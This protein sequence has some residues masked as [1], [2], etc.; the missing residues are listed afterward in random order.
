[1]KTI[2]ASSKEI[3]DRALELK[4]GNE[5]YLVCSNDHERDDIYEDL[6]QQRLWLIKDNLTK[7]EQVI[8][9]R[10]TLN[11]H[12]NVILTKRNIISAYINKPDGGGKIE[13]KF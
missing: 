8:I 9:D 4:I 7:Y 12:P 2:T 5:L 1:M 10:N 11:F 6:K 13:I 3:L